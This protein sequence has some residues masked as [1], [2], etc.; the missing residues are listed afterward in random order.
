[1]KKIIS[2][3]ILSIALVSC[4]E[5][6]IKDY[7]YSAVYFTHQID[8]RTVVV[9]EGLSVKIGVGLGGVMRNDI[10]R[11]VGFT[12]D[13][14]LITPEVLSDMKASSETYIKNSVNGVAALQ[15]MPANYYTLSNSNTMVIKSGQ[16]YGSVTLKVDSSAFLAD[17]AA[18]RATFA[19]PFFLTTAEADSILEPLRYSVIGIKYENMLFGNYLHGGVTTVKDAA[20]TTIQTIKYPTV[21]NQ[22]DDQIW[23]LTTSA[24]DAV[25][26]NGYSNKTSKT[27]QEL[28]LRLN[29]DDISVSSAAGSTNAYQADGSS[30]FNRAKL[31]QNRKIVLNYKYTSGANTY[32][33]QDTL[34]FRNRIRDG[35]NEWQDENPSHYLK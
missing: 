17:P 25:A 2:V 23:V 15:P 34:T 3:I 20:G 16:H 7:V 31:L 22:T 6:Y 30:T 10:D 8:V 1:M 12:L 32:Y 29:G 9:G 33:C 21:V 14:N 27:K 28:V 35:V 19:L 18:I 24:P 4:Y 13:N 11:S 5:D 26:A